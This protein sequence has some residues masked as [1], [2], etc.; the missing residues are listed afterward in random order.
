MAADSDLLRPWLLLIRALAIGAVVLALDYFFNL[1]KL[2]FASKAPLSRKVCCLKGV[3]IFGNAPQI[4][5]RSWPIEGVSTNAYTLQALSGL[6]VL[7]KDEIYKINLGPS[8]IYVL[9][10]A[11]HV[12][13]LLKSSKFINKPGEYDNFKPWLG[14]GLL[15][16]KAAKWR[17]RRKLLTPTFH[18]KILDSFQPIMSDK[19][20]LLVE[21]VRPFVNGEPFELMS[22]IMLCTLDIICETAMGYPVDA[23]GNKDSPF[24]NH[25]H[26]LSKGVMQRILDPWLWPK[27]LWNLSSPGRSF[28]KSNAFVQNFV[29]KVINER[30]T[31]IEATSESKERPVFLDLL[32]GQHL[33]DPNFT[34]KDMLDEVN[35]FMF[36]GQDTT[37]AGVNWCLFLIGHHLEE[38]E[39]VAE[40]LYRVFGE[41][42]E[43]NI[44]LD[45]L[46]E[47]KYLECVVKEG[48]RLFPSIPVIARLI[49]EDFWMDDILIPKGSAAAILNRELAQDPE[50]F[51]NP[52]SF[53]PERFLPENSVGRNPFAYVPFSAGPR[54]CI[55]QRYAILET[56]TLLAD[57]LRNFSV[58]SVDCVDKVFISPEIVGRPSKPL[59]FLI[60]PRIYKN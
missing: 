51:E 18:F 37:A 47:L 27:L 55:G 22:F 59:R 45:D 13:M 21:K 15:T 4:V 5:K 1:R 28:N 32:I 8:A 3:P 44:T 56:K 52:S 58:K 40:E 26:N 14:N 43:G 11:K 46:K 48:Q 6:C 34:E 24:V 38:Q 7:F 33:Q 36:A 31:E 2:I 57:I 17:P 53:S 35:T 29:A 60:E 42:R 19:S 9:H 49:D 39:K 50:H 41:D 10:K 20:K 25:L 12:E 16:S 30:K 54:N 23:L